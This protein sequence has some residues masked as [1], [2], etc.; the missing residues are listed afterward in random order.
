[1]YSSPLTPLSQVLVENST[2]SR[3]SLKARLLEEGLLKNQCYGCGL[4]PTWKDR[5]LVLHIEHRNG[6]KNDNRLENLEI[7]CPN[8]HSQ[9]DTYAGRNRRKAPKLCPGCNEPLVDRRRSYHRSCLKGAP[10][11]RPSKIEWPSQQDLVQMVEELGYRGTGNKLGVSDN[12]VRKRLVREA[13]FEPA[14]S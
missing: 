5:P 2:Y 6:I 12:A 14:T 11:Q 8:C 4:G 13:G 3:R 9:T 1:M 10:R 7:L